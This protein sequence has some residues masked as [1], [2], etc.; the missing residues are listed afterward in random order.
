MFYRYLLGQF[1]SFS[2]IISLFNLCLD[3]H[4]I[5]ESEIFEDS[6]YL[7]CDL[8]PSN[9]SFMNVGAFAFEA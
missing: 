3:D 9:V 5:G 1:E 6:H 7:M 8:S 2:F 4:S